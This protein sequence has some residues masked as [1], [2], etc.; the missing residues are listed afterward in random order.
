MK[1]KIPNLSDDLK[2]HS[3]SDNYS[4]Y[5]VER[6]YY[7]E[8]DEFP[9]ASIIED[10]PSPFIFPIQQDQIVVEEKENYSCFPFTKGE[11]IEKA[12]EK[13]GLDC[14]FISP[15]KISLTKQNISL[16]FK[17]TNYIINEKGEIKKKKQRKRKP[18]L[19]RK[20]IKA[21][22]HKDIKNVINSKLKSAG[23]HKFFDY[24]PQAFVT[25]IT[26]KVNKEALNLT[27]EKLLQTDYKYEQKNKKKIVFNPEETHKYKINSDVL[28]YLESHPEICKNSEFDKI[29][30][31][32]YKDILQAYF[33]SKEFEISLVDL[34]NKK[35]QKIEYMQAY[36][37][38]ALDYI[39]FFNN[40]KIRAPNP[41]I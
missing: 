7:P 21:R 36:I 11:G 32:K 34:Y 24:I 12:L 28:E 23:S 26:V 5:E 35:N 13:V 22:F 14:K 37:N 2:S 18:D 3:E 20:K 16:K 39:Y 4:D 17:T 40:K 27:Y 30:K 19:M 25:N 9:I 29:K 15:S 1:E 41:N 10:E 6:F 33:S 31:M 8:I 38:T